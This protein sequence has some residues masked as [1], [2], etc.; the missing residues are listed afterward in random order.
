ML[1]VRSIYG[2]IDVFGVISYLDS[3]YFC[4]FSDP[5]DLVKLK[6]LNRRDLPIE[7]VFKSVLELNQYNDPKKI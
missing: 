5:D 1:L 3:W 7:K 4:W 2:V 6:S